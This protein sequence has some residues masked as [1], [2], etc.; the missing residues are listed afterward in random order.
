MNS[1]VTVTPTNVQNC[2]QGCSYSVT[3]GSASGTE[4]LASSTG[5][6]YISGALGSGFTGESTTGQVTY[7][8]TL[9]NPAGSGT[10]CNFKVKYISVVA[11]E[12]T[13][14]WGSD[15]D[16]VTAPATTKKI[17]CKDAPGANSP[18]AKKL[19]MGVASGS[20]TVE[21]EGTSYTLT[22]DVNAFSPIDCEDGTE[23]T[24]NTSVP[25]IF[26]LKPN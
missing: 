21:L 1:T 15:G 5:T 3:K 17:K 23:Y 14:G 10:T 25:V 13:A 6:P 12:I 9:T 22:N 20:A 26:L 16:K 19:R 7:Y 11:F 24:L 18:Q 8:M 4:V 2:T